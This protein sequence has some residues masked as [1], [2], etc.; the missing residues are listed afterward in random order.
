[1]SENIINIVASGVSCSFVVSSLFYREVF[2]VFVTLFTFSRVS[3]VTMAAR[4]A[5]ASIAS[6]IMFFLMIL[7]FSGSRMLFFVASIII[8]GSTTY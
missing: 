6:F 5:V 4:V 2:V 8:I 3:G 1:M 7:V